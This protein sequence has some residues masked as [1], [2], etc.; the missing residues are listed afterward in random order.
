MIIGPYSENYLMNNSMKTVAN[1]KWNA[2]SEIRL[3]TRG[4]IDE[5]KKK[6]GKS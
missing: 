6:E 2:F 3:K 1:N 4:L 5:E